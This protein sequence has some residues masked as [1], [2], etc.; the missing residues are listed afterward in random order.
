LRWLPL[1]FVPGGFLLKQRDRKMSETKAATNYVRSPKEAAE[2]L[3]ISISTLRRLEQRGEGPQRIK[4]SDRRI[5]YP[6][7]ALAEFIAARSVVA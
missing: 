1:G 5:G 6:D 3:G 2:R 7:S 4:I